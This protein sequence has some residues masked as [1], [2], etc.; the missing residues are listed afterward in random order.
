[1]DM[2]CA[3]LTLNTCHGSDAPK[4]LVFGCDNV[5]SQVKIFATTL[6]LEEKISP[7]GQIFSLVSHCPLQ[8]EEEMV[9]R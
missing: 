3:V 1:M 7:L 9:E 2:G 5:D 6:G 4:Y 8:M